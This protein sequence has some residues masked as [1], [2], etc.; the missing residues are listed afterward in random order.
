MERV[1]LTEFWDR[2]RRRFGETYADS[3]A[4]DHVL[5]TLDGRTVEQALSDGEDAKMVWR[6]VC[7][8]FDVPARE[9]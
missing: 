1:R 9:R 3:L 6:A 8:G 7:E 4:R 5:S 2:M